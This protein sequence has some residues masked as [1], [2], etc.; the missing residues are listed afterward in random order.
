M[1]SDSNRA[2]Y[3]NPERAAWLVMLGAFA[4][5][6]MLCATIPLSIR[7]YLR[8]ATTPRTAMLEVVGGTV[9]VRER[10]A[11]APIAVT[12][13]IALSEGATIETDENSRG[14]VTFHDNSTTILFPSSQVILRAMHV[15]AYPWGIEPSTILIEQTRGRV[16]IGAAPTMSLANSEMPNRVFQ[17]QTPYFVS[18]FTDGSFAVEINSD[19]GQVTVRDGTAMVTAQN[20]T[21]N[22]GRSQ[23]TVVTRD[24]AP[25]PA[26][27]AS[28]DI[29]VNGDFI[30]PLA[31]GWSVVRESGNTPTVGTG[32]VSITTIAGRNAIH[33]ARTGSNQTSVVLGIV[34]QINREVS[35]Y[36]SLRL[37]ADVR[38]RSQSLSG[39]GMLSSEYPLILRLKYRDVYGS[40]A[41]WVH[42]FYVQNTTNNPTN[43]GEPVPV[44]VWIPF[45][46]GNLF[47]TV[48]PKPFF[49]TS[50]QIYASG[51]DYDSYVSA[52]RLVVE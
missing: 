4:V 42:G 39:G 9:R 2:K 27:P 48:D 10:G 36:R 47:E 46:A 37:S 25:L 21:V 30:D 38:V 18:S 51:W 50:L 29:I 3:G 14:I 5:F 19:G 26:L 22:V 13:S 11:A 35:D 23:R 41:E 49:I 20:R 24:G 6:L 8:H 12:R 43:N 44:D 15:S 32:A 45:E 33:I 40:E 1:T 34:Q 17:V 28:Q 7:Y 16:R 31:R 52:I